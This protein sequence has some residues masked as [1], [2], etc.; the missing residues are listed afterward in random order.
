MII[1]FSIYDEMAIPIVMVGTKYD[2]VPDSKRANVVTRSKYKA[3]EV[4][5]SEIHLV[6]IASTSW[7]R[8][9]LHCLKL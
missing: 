6:K 5:C 7:F 3:D 9:G 1:I 2:L 4:G 8:P